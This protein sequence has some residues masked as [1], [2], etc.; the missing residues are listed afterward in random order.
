M[1]GLQFVIENEIE[2]QSATEAELVIKTCPF[3]NDDR[4]KLYLNKATGLYNC[5][6]C[7]HSGNIYMLSKIWCFR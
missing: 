5:K 6:L 1:I 7:G 2:Y 4:Y 3:C